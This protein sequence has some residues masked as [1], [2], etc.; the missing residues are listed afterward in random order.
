MIESFIHG[1]KVVYSMRQHVEA[2]VDRLVNR[3]KVKIADAA[4]AAANTGLG[5]K[6]QPTP[7]M[8]PSPASI[9]APNSANSTPTNRDNGTPNV[10][11]G[12]SDSATAQ[13]A[14]T[15][16]RF[17]GP[18]LVPFPLIPD[19]LT[20]SPD[21]IPE[22]IMLAMAAVTE[23]VGPTFVQDIK[24]V[25][26]RLQ[27]AGYCMTNAQ[28]TLN[29]PVL[30]R[31]FPTTFARIIHTSLLPTEEHEPDFEDEEGELFWPG[32][33]ITGEGLGWVCLMGKAMISEFGKAYGYKGLNG[34]VPKP[35]PEEQVEAGSTGPPPQAQYRSNVTP[36][37]HHPS[38]S[39][40]SKW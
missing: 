13:P 17:S 14:T 5:P 15:R 23:P 9:A 12:R 7:P 11:S 6:S 1:R 39:M 35:K 19:H 25:T 33:I 30:M 22:H 3:V 4:E 27:S 10:S 26:A 16:P 38:S 18:T 36:Q 32:Q 8:L 29:L 34:V 20:K 24:D 21:P 37:G 2:D 31:C 28:A 40:A